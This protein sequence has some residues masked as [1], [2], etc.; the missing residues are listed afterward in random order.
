MFGADQLAILKHRGRT[1]WTRFCQETTPA[2]FSHAFLKVTVEIWKSY[3][4][5]IVRGVYI[6]SCLKFQQLLLKMYVE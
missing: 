5:I 1:S 3:L 4:Y 2:L 6:N